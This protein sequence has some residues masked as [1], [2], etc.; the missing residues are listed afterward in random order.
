MARPDELRLLAKVA[1]LYYEDGLRQTAIAERLALSQTTISRLLK[2]AEQEGIVRITVAA[3][4]GAYPRLERA[5]EARYALDEAIV[6]ECAEAAPD[7]EALIM[8]ELGR[9]AAFYVGSTLQPGEVLGL[10][11]LGS[12]VGLVDALHPLPS[13]LGVRAVQLSGGVGNPAAEEHQAQITRRL[14]ALLRGE[15]A[16]LPAPGL[17]PSIEARRALLEDPFVK[18]TLALFET[19]TLA[20]V[21]IGTTH[22]QGSPRGFMINFT[23]AERARLDTLGAVGF[24]CHRFFDASGASLDTPFD[25]RVIAMT[26]DQL[27]RV[28]RRVGICGGRSR[29]Q[30]MRGALEGR[31]VNVLITDRFAAEHLMRDASAR[32][33]D[34]TGGAATSHSSIAVADSQRQGWSDEARSESEL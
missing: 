4:Y 24:I 26:P 21:G 17:A 8:R 16:L 25:A 31:W 30:A 7:A 33:V 12:A 32:A 18:E 11:A 23:A 1:S 5:L 27:R 28:K 22:P 3:P 9:A 34:A 2:R 15:A 13:S 20:L 14:A 10:A 6:V 29:W 19:V